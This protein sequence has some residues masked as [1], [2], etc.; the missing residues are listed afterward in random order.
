MEITQLIHG[1]KLK[2]FKYIQDH[3]IYQG[4]FYHNQF[5]KLI[6]EY[7][8]QNRAKAFKLAIALEQQ[9]L[10]PIISVEAQMIRKVW[11]E[12]QSPID[13]LP[14]AWLTPNTV[15]Q[16]RMPQMIHRWELKEFNFVRDQRVC[17]GAIYQGQFYELVRHREVLDG[18][19]ALSFATQLARQGHAVVVSVEG[20][21]SYQIW[22][23]M[24]SGPAAPVPASVPAN[25]AMA[26]SLT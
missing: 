21:T 11:V 19:W 6:A 18:S 26:S 2:T 8:S 23:E 15:E 20:R 10:K 4:V 16:D 12:V 25:R 17:T 5:Y 1:D 3:H 22:V 24:R 9:G 7:R 14:L 13:P